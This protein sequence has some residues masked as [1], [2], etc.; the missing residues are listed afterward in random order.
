MTTIL[1][2]MKDAGPLATNWLRAAVDTIA[3]RHL[4][5]TGE[6]PMDDLEAFL[7]ETKQSPRARRLAYEWIVR[8]DPAAEA[9]LMPKMLHDP[10]LELR[11]DAVARVLDA[12]A[13]AEG[14][15]AIAFY[16]TAL[17]AVR[18]LDQ[19]ETCTKA[20][21]KLGKQVD[22]ATKL[23]FLTKW[24]IIGP[25]D[26]TDRNG[27]AAV[28]SPENK[29][30]FDTAYPGK[31][32]EVKWID[33][34]TDEGYGIVDLTT[35]LDKHKG[36]AAYAAAEFISD[37][38]RDI[39][40]RLGCIN[41]HKLWVNGKL[42]LQNEVYHAGMNVDQYIGM[43]KLRPGKNVILL[44]VCQNEQTE[45][46]AQRWQFQLRVTDSLGGAVLAMTKDE[47]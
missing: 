3:E 17:D 5:K 38:A 26:N 39:E 46:W 6:L 10:S 7:F 25:F 22:T 35:A 43:A 47:G 29:T 2:G 28:Y 44:K 8:V 30:D 41:A 11:R 27:Y 1:A 32:G 18:D 12:A 21:E 42:I 23:G 9:R 14:D 13:K 16:E 40:L 36:A 4:N 15:E 37:Q 20:L 33:Y 45:S 31:L 24:K 19:V 34:Q